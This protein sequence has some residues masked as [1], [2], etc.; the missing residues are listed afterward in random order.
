[1]N[2]RLKS[3]TAW[4]KWL[5]RALWRVLV[6]RDASVEISIDDKNDDQ[7]N[8][9]VISISWV[10]EVCQDLLCVL[11][12]CVISWRVLFPLPSW[13]LG[14]NKHF[15]RQGGLNPLPETEASHIKPYPQLLTPMLHLG[16]KGWLYVNKK[17]SWE[18]EETISIE[19]SR[20]L[21]SWPLS[22]LWVWT[23]TM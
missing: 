5:W 12:P 15:T 7:V 6:V 19:S 9:K 17:V 4:E 18:E 20:A 23:K 11:C 1:M 3:S 16:L 10:V 13:K 21:D 2:T 22:S 8:P 14:R